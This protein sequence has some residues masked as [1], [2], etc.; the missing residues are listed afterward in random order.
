[1]ASQLPEAA[2]ALLNP[3]IYPDK[4]TSVEM[5]QTQ[6]SFIFLTGKYVYKLKKPVDLGFLDYTTLDRRRFFCE[7]EVE[8]NRRLCPEV[9]LGVIPVTRQKTG[10][11]L[12]K[13]GETV[14]FTVKMLYLPQDCMLN[15][16]LERNRVQPEMLERVAQKLADFHSRAATNAWIS[17]FG[18]LE[19]VKVN[20]DQNFSQTLPYLDKAVTSGQIN[21]LKNYTD[22][23]YTRQAGLLRQ[24]AEQQKIRDC[25]GDLHAQHICFSDNIYIY[26]C[27][28]FSDRFRYC[29]VA[30]EIAFL[31]MDL[32]HHG[33]ADLS[34]AFVEAYISASGD[35]QIKD[36][37]KFYKIYRAHVRGKVGCFK[38]N[39]HYISE[40]ERKQ[41]LEA[42]R[43]YFE[44]ADSYAHPRP[45]LFIT[46]G[47]VG[48]GKSTLAQTISKRLGLSVL[49]SDIIRKQ[50]AGIAPTE[51]RF[52]EI[53]SGIYS[54]EFSQKTYRKMFAEAEV[55]LKD[56][57]SVIMDATFL[58]AEE[59]RKAAA[60]AQATGADFFVIECRLDEAKTRQRLTQRLKNTA[61]SDGRWEIYEPQKRK[62]EPVTEFPAGQ[63]F[64][65]DSAR[66]L[67]E[68]VGNIIDRISE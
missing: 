36:L 20:T 24:R 31:A 59:R 26:D 28:E 58:K 62:F 42:A 33:R 5:M 35:R 63:V 64:S 29:D 55:I 7:Q 54:A 39:D 8:L 52:E 30:S 34:R 17:S 43:G 65:I 18:R 15:V 27:I 68:Q 12:G 44:L 48:S 61:I 67:P 6:M 37:L 49:S 2:Q 57:D 66:N 47:L 56:G 3:G 22:D 11:A 46:V 23:F 51:H 9:Y 32:D 10:L 53:D 14:D 1:M 13:S 45:R 50:L 25:H 4:T 21:R 19:A 38:Y 40:M 16:L 60:L 41:T